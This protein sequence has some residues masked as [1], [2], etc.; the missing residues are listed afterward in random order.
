MSIESI[1]QPLPDLLLQIKNS[2][3]NLLSNKYTFRHKLRKSLECILVSNTGLNEHQ[4]V[5][6]MVKD[7]YIK[8]LQLLDQLAQYIQQL[9]KILFHTNCFVTSEYKHYRA[10]QHAIEYYS[11]LSKHYF[12]VY[13]IESNIKDYNLRT[14]LIH[15]NE[16]Y[17]QLYQ[18]QSN[19]RTL[20][21]YLDPI[22]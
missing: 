14:A 2:I 8:H 17:P 4:E 18:I 16:L 19:I 21:Q 5:L 22:F 1:L 6:I 15:E 20:T 13:I 11:V 12:Q 7:K 3:D 10:F 9:E